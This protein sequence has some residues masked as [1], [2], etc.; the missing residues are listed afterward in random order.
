MCFFLVHVKM[1]A[2]QKGNRH[3]DFTYF[4]LKPKYERMGGRFEEMLPVALVPI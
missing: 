4:T 3:T 2:Q 1:K